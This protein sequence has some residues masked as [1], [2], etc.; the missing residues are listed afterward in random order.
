MVQSC[1]SVPGRPVVLQ[2]LDVPVDLV[3]Q[4]YLLIQWDPGR[5][6]VH[7]V[8]VNLVDLVVRYLPQIQVSPYHPETQ[9]YR[10][11]LGSLMDRRDQVLQTNLVD[12]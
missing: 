12:P 7:L 2:V 9:S 6:P 5:L 1:L 8:P 3:T 4:N 11:D 10:M